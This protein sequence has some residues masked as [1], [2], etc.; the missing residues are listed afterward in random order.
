MYREETEYIIVIS[1][2]NKIKT[3][4]SRGTIDELVS[5]KFKVLKSCGVVRKPV[6]KD[7]VREENIGKIFTK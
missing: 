7:I 1:A 2:G 4:K 6:K 3:V 5:I